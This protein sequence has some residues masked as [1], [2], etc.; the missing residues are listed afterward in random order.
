MSEFNH[1]R[2]LDA[3]SE[4][5]LVKAS[6]IVDSNGQLQGRRGHAQVLRQSGLEDT[7]ETSDKASRENVYMV[8]MRQNVLIVVFDESIEFERLR[9]AVDVLIRHTGLDKTQEPHSS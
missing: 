6:I 4:N 3:L 8:E 1:E 2:L 9:N 5:S 7:T